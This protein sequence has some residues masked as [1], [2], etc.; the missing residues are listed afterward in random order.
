MSRRITA[1]ML[2]AGALVLVSPISFAIAGGDSV[3]CKSKLLPVTNVSGDGTKC[4]ISFF[5]AGP[6]KAIADA[7][8][9]GFA[10]GIAGNGASVNVSA[11]DNGE[12]DADV[13]AGLGKATASGVGSLA[14]LGVV[15]TGGGSATAKGPNAIASSLITS[16]NGGLAKSTAS[17]D[18]AATAEVLSTGPLVPFGNGGSAVANSSQGGAAIAVVQLVGGGRANATASGTGTEADS[19]VDDICNASTNAKGDGSLAT[20]TCE[21]KGSTVSAEATN[22][23]TAEGS[24]TAPPTCNPAPGGKA[25]VRSP[26][27]N[28]G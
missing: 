12:A 10:H 17:A 28:C 5:G 23:S 2:V 25:K 16:A 8:S 11:K 21:T 14:M 27:G 20:A 19:A 22:G 26:M 9:L 15:L 7:S 13:S 1:T 24:D 6:N 3:S 4:E 18:S